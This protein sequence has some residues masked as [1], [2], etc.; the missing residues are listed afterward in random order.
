VEELE[1]VSHRVDGKEHILNDL[2]LLVHALDRGALRQLEQRDLRRNH[3]AKQVPEH[4]VVAKR[5]YI[6]PTLT[7]V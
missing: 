1:C 4:G 2:I 5:N 3:P 7:F 6:L